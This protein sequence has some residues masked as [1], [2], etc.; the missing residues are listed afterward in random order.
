MSVTLLMCRDG[1]K[2]GIQEDIS[3]PL[4]FE[5]SLCQAGCVGPIWHNCECALDAFL[6]SEGSVISSGF[7]RSEGRSYGR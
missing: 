7:M 2:T 6:K 5:A 3:A 1:Y 4:A